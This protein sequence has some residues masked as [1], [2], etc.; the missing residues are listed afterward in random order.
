MSTVI[1]ATS[2]L[3]SQKDAVL[4]DEFDS[5]T[6]AAH[7]RLLELLALCKEK[8]SRELSEKHSPDLATVIQVQ[9]FIWCNFKL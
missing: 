2:C 9:I 3:A 5:L 1:Q 4:Y 8:T 6:A 7:T